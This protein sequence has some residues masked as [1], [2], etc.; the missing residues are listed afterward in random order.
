MSNIPVVPAGVQLVPTWRIRFKEAS[1][2]PVLLQMARS[3]AHVAEPVASALAD[4]NGLVALVKDDVIGF[5]TYAA[6]E[7]EE[8]AIELTCLV[9]HP[10]FRSRGVGSALCTMLESIVRRA[11]GRFTIASLAVTSDDVE[12]HEASI[13]FFTRRGY[14]PLRVEPNSGDEGRHRLLLRLDLSEEAAEAAGDPA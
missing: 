14:R 2:A 13:R 4:Q 9:V 12:T 7:E 1:D 5:L 11:G 6:A 3:H 10:T 8:D